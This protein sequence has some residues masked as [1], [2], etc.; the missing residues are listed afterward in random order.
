MGT[1]RDI[2]WASI[3]LSLIVAS[4]LGAQ[5]AAGFAAQDDPAR[6]VPKSTTAPFRTLGSFKWL[7]VVEATDEDGKIQ[8]EF[9]ERFRPL[10]F[11][12]FESVVLPA[13]PANA[14]HDHLIATVRRHPSIRGG[15]IVEFRDFEK[16]L[17]AT[18]EGSPFALRPTPTGSIIRVVT[19][20]DELSYQTSGADRIVGSFST[21]RIRSLSANTSDLRDRIAAR[22]RERGPW[23]IVDSAP[24]NTDDILDCALAAKESIPPVVEF[25]CVDSRTRPVVTIVGSNCR[26]C[27]RGFQFSPK[28]DM[29]RAADDLA[30]QLVAHRTLVERLYAA[31]LNR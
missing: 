9:V 13:N 31:Q 3:V 10:P 15:V 11:G 2:R 12:W 29:K 23:M 27:L 30:D 26:S 28:G 6:L 1:Y 7:H 17:I 20:L 19:M 18:V 25:K 8:R 24:D 4:T 5:I 16:R 14:G 21:L 22:L